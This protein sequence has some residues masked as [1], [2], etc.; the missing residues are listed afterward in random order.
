M[1]VAVFAG[2]FK[3]RMEFNSPIANVLFSIGKGKDQL[4]QYRPSCSQLPTCCSTWLQ[5]LYSWYE[6]LPSQL[7][8]ACLAE[9]KRLLQESCQCKDILKSLS[10]IHV[11]SGADIFQVI[12]N[13]SNQKVHFI[14]LFK[15][16]PVLSAYFVLIYVPT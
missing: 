1:F 6:L 11:T 2:R 13:T 9:K 14:L 8:Q 7:A 10:F 4:T 12:C 5:L 16:N 15:L 3:S